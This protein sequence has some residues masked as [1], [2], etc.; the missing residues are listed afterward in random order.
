M[1][2]RRIGNYLLGVRLGGGGM[3]EVYRA[4]DEKLNRDVAVKLI[5]PQARSLARFER[6]VEILAAVKHP[7]LVHIYDFGKEDDGLHWLAM[8]LVE[9]E[10]LRQKMRAIGGP[11]KLGEAVQYAREIAE[12][13]AAV[14]DEGVVHRDLKVDNVILTADGHVK[15]IDFG[16]AKQCGDA[17]TVETGV[18]RDGEVIGT[19]Y[20][21]SPEQINP[22][23]IESDNRSDLYSLGVLIYEM[24]TGKPPFDE[25]DPG[26]LLYCICHKPHRPLAQLGLEIPQA[27]SNLVDELLEKNREYRPAAAKEV[28]QQ[29]E[30]LERKTSGA[31]PFTTAPLSPPGPWSTEPLPPEPSPPPTPRQALRWIVAA[32]AAVMVCAVA[33]LLRENLREP[34]TPEVPLR[35]SL[36]VLELR[37]DTGRQDLEWYGTAVAENLS[38]ELAV[39]GDL[40]VLDSRWLSRLGLPSGE[41]SPLAFLGSLRMD[42]FLTGSYGPDDKE[43][44]VYLTLSLTAV[45]SQVIE[46]S[47]NGSIL[48]EQLDR[49]EDF[50]RDVRRALGLPVLDSNQQHIVRDSLPRGVEVARLYAEG[51][52]HLRRFEG[53][54]AA[55]LFEAAQERDPEA[56]RILA[57]LA[58]AY[59]LQ[60][61]DEDARE[62]AT[63]AEAFTDRLPEREK[64]LV[65]ARFHELHREW[66]DAIAAYLGAL[67][68]QPDDIETGLLLA[69]VQVAARKPGD[70]LDTLDR[71]PLVDD[72][73]RAH[74]LRAEAHHGLGEHQEQLEAARRAEELSRALEANDLTAQALLLRAVAH[75]L[76][77]HKD[78]ALA[79]W[80]EVHRL[81]SAGRNTLTII[82]SRESMAYTLHQAGHLAAAADLYDIVLAQYRALGH[83][84]GEYRTLSSLGTIRAQQGRRQEAEDL[85]RQALCGFETQADVPAA[86]LVRM[87]LGSLAIYRGDLEGAESL[88]EQA[89]QGFVDSEQRLYQAIAQ[90]NLGEARYLRG[91][92]AAS[93][94]LHKMAHAAKLDAG[95][96][97]Y[98]AY[99]TCRQGLVFAAQGSYHAAESRFQQALEEHEAGGSPDR[100]DRIGPGS[101]R[102]APRPGRALG[103]AGAEGRRNPAGRGRQRRRRARPHPR[104][105]ESA[106]PGPDRGSDTVPPSG[107]AAGQS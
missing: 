21:M 18:T 83:R 86:A 42:Y 17:Q 87:E 70:A 35:E 4:R 75:Q 1:K 101:S 33:W 20:A 55:A 58:E 106:S 15:L 102:L 97:F 10:T 103:G 99:D 34:P 19:L 28:F 94:E 39:G 23:G 22:H 96:L 63:R 11:L 6:E 27:L 61:R 78:E 50:G 5:R 81:A 104:G 13:L 45:R 77:G 82:R 52:R 40:R 49:L 30:K 44:A 84:Q 95:A 72:D 93:M 60:G 59:R 41:L 107:D 92:L 71:L 64:T 2:Q 54:K 98:A 91:E 14:H 37:N 43:G 67:E 47:Y 65:E 66:D 74:L 85:F 8:E 53:A 25:P 69:T 31:K 89:V 73:P 16:L 100:R 26:P 57:A 56:A 24:L 105:I 12:T 36:V 32:A 3:G 48:P 9:G 46:W 68:K 80:P 79:L 7:F 90:T 29:L 62:T 38:V 76:L 51:L 88:Y